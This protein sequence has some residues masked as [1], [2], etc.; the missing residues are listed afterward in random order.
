MHDNLLK[1]LEF[2]TEGDTEGGD[3]SDNTEEFKGVEWAAGA[4]EN[5]T[6]ESRR[7]GENDTV[8][9]SGESGDSVQ[10]SLLKNFELFTE[11]DTEGG[12]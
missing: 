10:D 2:C 5:D 1:N 8:E 6:V 9:D 7:V 11:G 4:R 3:R 12:D